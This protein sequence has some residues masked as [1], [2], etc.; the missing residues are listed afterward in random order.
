MNDEERY[1]REAKAAIQGQAMN[2]VDS[3]PYVVFE[4][5]RRNFTLVGAKSVEEYGKVL[6]QVVKEAG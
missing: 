6:G 2:D 4:G 1:L 5:K 3:V